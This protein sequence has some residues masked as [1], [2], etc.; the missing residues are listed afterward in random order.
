MVNHVEEWSEIRRT[1]YPKVADVNGMDIVDDPAIYTPGQLINPVV[2][3]LGDGVFIKRLPF[4]EDAEI[5]NANTPDQPGIKTKV[6]WDQ[7]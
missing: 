7:K 1:H 3:V 6:W 5:R 4:P 2:D